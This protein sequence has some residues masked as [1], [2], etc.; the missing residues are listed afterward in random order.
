MKSEYDRAGYVAVQPDQDASERAR[1][2]PAEEHECPH[3]ARLLVA[4]AAR[5]RQQRDDPVAGDDA[6]AEGR[7]VHRAQAVEAAVGEDAPGE[8][9]AVR[10]LRVRGGRG[11]DG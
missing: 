1:H 10:A 3:G 7:G 8:A 2:Q 5:P 6:E 11:E 9:L 4:E